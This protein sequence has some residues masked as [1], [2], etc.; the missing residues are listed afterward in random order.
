MDAKG[1]RLC[2]LGLTGGACTMA[3]A[4]TTLAAIHHRGPTGDRLD[5]AD[6][7]LCLAP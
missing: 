3:R 2:A 7:L 5:V 1:L 4:A 6:H